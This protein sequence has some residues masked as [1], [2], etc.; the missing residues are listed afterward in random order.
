MKGGLA[1]LENAV[2]GHQ[3]GDQREQKNG[4]SGAAAVAG[5]CKGEAAN[6]GDAHAEEDNSRGVI[7]YCVVEAARW[8]GEAVRDP[9]GED[10]ERPAGQEQK[11]GEDQNVNDAREA[12]PRMPPLRQPETQEPAQPCQWPVQPEIPLRPQE[13]NQPPGRDVGET[14][15]SQ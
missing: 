2:R 10:R 5:R 13:W 4:V 14:E 7:P 6:D 8:A 11:A 1:A 3:D 9:H 15:E 12:V